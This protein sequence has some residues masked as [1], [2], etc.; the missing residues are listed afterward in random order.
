LVAK[1]T[2]GKLK[3]LQEE[4][5]RIAP[6]KGRV[7]IHP[8]SSP[9]CCS[10]T[11][12]DSL[13]ECH[14]KKFTLQSRELARILAANLELLKFPPHDYPLL[15]EPPAGEGKKFGWSF[16][17]MEMIV[18]EC[19]HL[20]VGFCLDTC[21]VF[22]SGV[23]KFDSKKNVNEFFAKLQEINV[24]ERVKAIHFNDSQHE[25]GEMK[26]RHAPI[27]EGYIW[28]NPDHASGLVALFR[29]CYLYNIDVICEV[30]T[31]DDLFFTK[32]LIDK[33]SA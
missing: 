5:D 15:L 2:V 6:F 4:L 17:H 9:C 33:V 21:H 25:F 28:N 32:L 20:P 22:C 3:G 1:Q 11:N 24:L 16:E 23:C 8:N 27:G 31:D 14:E 19:G 26:D 30:G 10:L 18:K 7:V 12:R 13:V 29:W